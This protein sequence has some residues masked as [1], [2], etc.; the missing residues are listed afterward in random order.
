[1]EIIPVASRAPEVYV[2]LLDNRHR[3][4]INQTLKKTNLIVLSLLN[5]INN[6]DSVKIQNN[7]LKVFIDCNYSQVRKRDNEMW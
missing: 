4:G 3:A 2:C 7:Y 1:M 6:K 5:K